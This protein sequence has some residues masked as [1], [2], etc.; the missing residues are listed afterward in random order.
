MRDALFPETCVWGG[1]FFQVFDLRVG[2]ESVASRDGSAVSGAG[3]GKS[4][5]G[6]IACVL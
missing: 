4:K 5:G 3:L 1:G 2:A 6:C